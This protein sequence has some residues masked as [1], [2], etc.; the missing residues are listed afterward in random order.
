MVSKHYLGWDSFDKLTGENMA[1]RNKK[2]KIEKLDVK[3]GKRNKK[4][5]LIQCGKHL[6]SPTDVR[7]ITKVR[8]DLY[9][10]KFFSDPN[11][12]FPCWIEAKDIGNLL[13]QFDIIEGD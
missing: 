7:V 5:M 10:V 4:P 13:S 3:E 9:V 1:P 2:L 8:K 11:P 6:L 12:E